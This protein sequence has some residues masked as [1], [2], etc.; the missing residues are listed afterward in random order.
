VTLPASAGA[1]FDLLLSDP[2]LSDKLGVYV[3]TDQSQIP[4]IATMFS[5]ERLMEGSKPQGVEVMITAMPVSNPD[6]I[7]TGEVLPNYNW[8]IYVSLWRP[9]D[10]RS[11]LLTV[12]ER[13]VALLPG[14]SPWSPISGDPPGGGLG[15]LE[16]VVINWTNSVHVLSETEG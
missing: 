3:L 7:V 4:A 9:Y 14:P 16:Q 12:C 1:I 2:V 5:N 10:S 15:L 13:I 6:Q 11:D 8:R